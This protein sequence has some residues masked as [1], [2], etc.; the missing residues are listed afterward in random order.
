MNPN[1]TRAPIASLRLLLPQLR[2]YLPRAIGAGVALLLA[3][4]MTLAI[5][6]G[7]KG[8]IDNGFSGG[9]EGLN[10]AALAMGGI[11][12]VLAVATSARYYLVSWLGERVAADLRRRVFDHVLSL[13]PAFFE[14]ART[15]DILSR[16]TAD[17]G[18]LQSLI[19]SAISM[20]LRNALTG[21]GA[22]AML[23]ATSAKLAGIM[24]VVLPLVVAPLVLFGRRERRLSRTAQ[25]RV[26]DLAAT[27]EEALNG[28]RIV[29]AFTHEPQDRKR[30]GEEVER[31]VGAALRR[32]ASRTALILAVILFGFGAITF[33]LWVGGQDVVAGRMTGGELSAFVFYAVLLASSGATMSELWGEIQ[34]AAAAADRLLEILAAKPAIAAPAH[35]VALPVPAAGRLAFEEVGFRYPTRPDT[36]ALDGFSLI[37][38]P[39]ETVALVGP[40]G[41]GKTTVFQLLLRFYDPQAG[42]VMVD[43]VDVAQADPAALRARIGIVPQ[44]PAIFS[45]SVAENIR[46]GRP[47]A[48]DA[49]VRAA[50]EAAAADGF[51]A[52]LP[53]GYDTH[54]GA[55]GVT[56]SGGQRQ[57]IAIA[58]AI[59]RDAPILLLDEATS[60]LDAESE[61]AVQQAL[62]ALSRGRTT[63]VVAHRLATVRNADRIV[64]M[65]AGRIVA[66][67]THEALV[68]EGGLY[69]RLAALQFGEG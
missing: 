10:G 6:Q 20:G 52:R 3:A 39:G 56:L 7:L 66:M 41:A 28:L 48:T 67:G 32:I 61:Q 19:G 69:A 4:A 25:E 46:Y 57:R 54:L 53:Q 24:L 42:R 40:S 68:R 9:A 58:R 30:F 2:P 64:V 60:A 51:I 12:A 16:M 45:A 65:E 33:S 23:V 5:G 47:D 31:S 1:P 8:L 11:V 17:V 13:S 15:G 43:G 49:E 59:L 38:E 63:L 18:L 27:A 55:R 21:L 37:V 50:A 44:D 14:T 22:L 62:E 36:A 34:R 26:A 29:Q 35:P